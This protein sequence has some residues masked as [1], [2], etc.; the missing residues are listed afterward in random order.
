MGLSLFKFENLI[1]MILFVTVFL[2]GSYN[3][4]RKYD[5]Y[6]SRYVSCIRSRIGIGVD[7]DCLVSI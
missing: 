3:S 2:L 7:L 4:V 1:T 5:L 6:K